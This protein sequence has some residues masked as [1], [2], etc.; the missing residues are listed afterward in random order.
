VSPWDVVVAGAGNAALC[1]ALAAR[2]AGA[3]VLVLERAPYEH[4][5]G[6]TAFTAGVMRTTYDGVD[7]VLELCP[8]LSDKELDQADF[9]TYP[10][11]RFL[12][13]LGRMTDY[14]TDPELADALAR[15]ALDTLRWM[16]S[17]GVRFMPGY[18]Q[19]L[20]RQDGKYVFPDG[21]TMEVSGGGAGLV[22]AL[23]RACVDAGVDI[24]YSAPALSLTV[25]R[26]GRVVG[27]S[28]RLNGSV[29]QL[30]AGAVVLGCGGF[31]AN[32]EWRARYLGPG[33]DL[34]KVRGSR[35]S[36]G[37]GLRMAL[38]V[39]AMPFG[40]WSGVH[41][42]S[43]ELNAPVAGDRN[44]APGFHKTGYP[45]GIM[46]NARGERFVDEGAH[47]RS[48]TAARY[49]PA[50]LQQPGQLAWQVFDSKVAH[51]LGAEYRIR[52]ATRVRAETLQQLAARLDGVD[53]EGFLRTVEAY[54][55]AV[56]TDVPFDP[57]TLDGRSTTGLAV[58]KSNWATTV[59]TPPFEAYAVTCGVTFTFGG[60]R[61]DTDA[62]VLDTDEVPIPGLYACGEMVG[63][64]F[65]HNYVDGAGLASGAVFGRAAGAA[66]G[67]LTTGRTPPEEVSGR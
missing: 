20:F 23:T 3:S 59:D 10:V 28:A 18:S 64:L 30:T 7:D 5:G 9:G 42:T 15:R 51:L 67:L 53:E 39:G 4:R 36:T 26:T 40:H 35:F 65:Y 49:G 14:R 32:A 24:R 19:Q 66:A 62:Q 8:G 63:G 41:A 11:E 29:E 22:D 34:A 56:R 13:D 44:H 31:G 17:K 57:D 27:L 48:H 21:L 45:F 46:V 52:E 50:I 37:D 16:T 12:D 25:D 38:D 61:I 55:A 60:L 54:N 43:W 47:Y 2:D 33:W 1:A 6:N 58:P